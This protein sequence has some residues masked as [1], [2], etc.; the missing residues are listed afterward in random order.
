[1]KL[2]IVLSKEET[3]NWIEDKKSMRSLADLNAFDCM[4]TS[5]FV[6]VELL[7]DDQVSLKIIRSGDDWTSKSRVEFN[8]GFQNET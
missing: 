8:K 3:K 7:T 6:E 5:C 1:M 2:Q 4:K